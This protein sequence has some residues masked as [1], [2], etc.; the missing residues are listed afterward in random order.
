MPPSLELGTDS[1]PAAQG[2]VTLEEKT[3]RAEKG[4]QLSQLAVLGHSYLKV[5]AVFL[6]TR[7][8][9]QGTGE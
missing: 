1:L 8:G 5:K 7:D 9:M 4:V 2:E 6:L 3:R